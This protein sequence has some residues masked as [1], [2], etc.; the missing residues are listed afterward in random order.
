MAP[1]FLSKPQQPP[2]WPFGPSSWLQSLPSLARL[3]SASSQCLWPGLPVPWLPETRTSLILP[4]TQSRFL[5][6]SSP[7]LR[8]EGKKTKQN[9]IKQDCHAEPA[10]TVGTGCV[11]CWRLLFACLHLKLL[12]TSVD[13]VLLLFSSQDGHQSC[14]PRKPK[15]LLLSEIVI[16]PEPDDSGVKSTFLFLLKTLSFWKMLNKY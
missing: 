13:S 3:L 8:V 15:L 4:G 7:A 6:E 14:P 12:L 1:S 16:S 10:W 9:R 2:A 5:G 11:P